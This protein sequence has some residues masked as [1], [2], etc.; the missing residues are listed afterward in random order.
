MMKR[1]KFV[2]DYTNEFY[3]LVYMDD[4]VEIEEHLV[5]RY[6]NGLLQSIQNVLCL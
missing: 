4:P 2:N 6:L 1:G 5:A 3:Q